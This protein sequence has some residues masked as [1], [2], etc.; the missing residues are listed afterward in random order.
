MIK[1][2]GTGNLTITTDNNTN[3]IHK[4]LYSYNRLSLPFSSIIGFVP[5]NI[6]DNSYRDYN[7]WV[8]CGLTDTN[9]NIVLFSYMKNTSFTVKGNILH[10]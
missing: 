2:Y 6:I 5:L 1:Y 8:V 3:T 10:L 7:G 9:L 4:G